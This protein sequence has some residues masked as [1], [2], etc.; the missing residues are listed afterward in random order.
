MSYVVSAELGVE[1]ETLH[2]GVRSS[3]LYTHC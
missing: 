1:L 2:R 3:E